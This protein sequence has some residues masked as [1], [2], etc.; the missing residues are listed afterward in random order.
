MKTFLLTT[1]LNGTF[2]ALLLARNTLEKIWLWPVNQDGRTEALMPCCQSI[3][4]FHGWQTSHFGGRAAFLWSLN[5]SADTN[6]SLGLIQGKYLVI[7]P[8]AYRNQQAVF[9]EIPWAPQV[10]WALSYVAQS[11]FLLILFNNLRV[12][13]DEILTNAPWENER[14]SGLLRDPLYTSLLGRKAFI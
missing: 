1:W 9:C 2:S 13:K 3:V 14:Y 12:C 6:D 8:K 11:W 7:W 5:A 4:C 10:E